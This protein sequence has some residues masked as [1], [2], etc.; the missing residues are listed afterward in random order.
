MNYKKKFL[1]KLYTNDF[2][3]YFDLDRPHLSQLETP[4]TKKRY[5]IQNT[6][7]QQGVCLTVARSPVA[8]AYCLGLVERP[9]PLARR[10]SDHDIR[11]LQ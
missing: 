6:L 3:R 8:S 1:Y 5:Y 2:L 9:S 7:F 4:Y 11:F 10:A